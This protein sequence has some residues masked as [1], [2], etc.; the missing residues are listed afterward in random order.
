MCLRVDPPVEELT[1]GHWVACH[2]HTRVMRPV[3]PV[4]RAGKGMTANCSRY[5]TSPRFIGSAA[6][7]GAP[8]SHAV[9]DFNLSIEG[10]KPVIL[11]VVGESG[12][13][14]TTLARMHVTDAE[15][16][17]GEIAID[18][19]TVF[20]RQTRMTAQSSCDLCSRSSRTRLSPL[21][22]ASRWTTICTRRRSIWASAA[23]RGDAPVVAEALRGSVL[24]SARRRQVPEPVLGRRVAAHLG[25]ARAHSA[26]R[27]S[28]SPTNRSA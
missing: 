10:D 15:P 22:A 18:G 4:S 13:G 24:T 7:S 9:D 5:K 3:Q 26:T 11:S 2:L 20:T 17:A 27:G 12:S 21:V 19:R 14:K 25:G 8:S 6:S 1:P 16:T 28:S 23:E